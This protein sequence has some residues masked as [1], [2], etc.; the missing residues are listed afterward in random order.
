LH[1]TR[2]EWFL[3]F[4]KVTHLSDCVDLSLCFSSVNQNST[5]EKRF[6]LALSIPVSTFVV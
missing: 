4:E 3:L 6:G 2:P 5:C 1:E